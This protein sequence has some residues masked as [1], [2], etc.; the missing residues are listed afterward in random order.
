[1]VLENFSSFTLKT[2]ENN[3]NMILGSSKSLNKKKKGGFL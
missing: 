3:I 2:K 1:M